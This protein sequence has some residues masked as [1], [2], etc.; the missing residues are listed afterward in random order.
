M[1]MVHARGVTGFP[2]ISVGEIRGCS[3]PVRTL[4][5]PESLYLYG[6]NNSRSTP[7]KKRIFRWIPSRLF[8]RHFYEC[9]QTPNCRILARDQKYGCLLLQTAAGETS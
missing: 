5:V 6:C 4:P 1:A 2:D 8:E 3:L 7:M 9:C